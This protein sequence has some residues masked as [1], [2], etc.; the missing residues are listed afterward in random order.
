MHLLL[1]TFALRNQLRDYESFFVTV[2]GNSVQWCHYIENTILVYT[3]Y[4]ATDFTKKLLPHFEITDSILVVPVTAPLNGWLPPDAW[5]WIN[6]II[7]GQVP[8]LP[9]PPP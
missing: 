2:R 6:A 1:V 3:P 8:K 4:P 7:G 5:N 9:A